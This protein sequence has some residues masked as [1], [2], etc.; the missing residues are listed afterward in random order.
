VTALSDQD[1]LKCAAARRAVAEIE[2]GVMLGLGSGST[3]ALR[4][5]PSPTRSSAEP[6]HLIKG[7]GGAFLRE[8]IVAAASARMIVVVNESSSSIA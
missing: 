5:R 2:E 8:K 4:S 7:G 1:T 3:A 6:L